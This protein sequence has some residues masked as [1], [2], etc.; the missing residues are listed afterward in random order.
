[1]SV[2]KVVDFLILAWSIFRKIMTEYG[3]RNYEFEVLK[4]RP[5]N[6][7]GDSQHKS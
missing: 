2:T 4:G 5:S 1:M 7:E 6:D 3:K